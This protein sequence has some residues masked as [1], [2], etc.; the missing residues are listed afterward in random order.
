[1]ADTP[2]MDSCRKEWQLQHNLFNTLKDV[3]E[4]HYSVRFAF[5]I[6]CRAFGHEPLKEFG[7][8][9]NL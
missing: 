9:V 7:Q 3:A 1:M 5:E 8:E 4:G 2:H 6:I